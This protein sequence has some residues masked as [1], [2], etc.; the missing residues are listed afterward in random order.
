LRG[1]QNYEFHI[2]TAEVDQ[3]ALVH[4]VWVFSKQ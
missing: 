2:F 4:R 3:I 1:T